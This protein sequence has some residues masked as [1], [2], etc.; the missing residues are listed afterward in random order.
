MTEPQIINIESLRA[1]PLPQW[2]DE[3]SKAD[4]G[5]LLVIAGSRRLAGAALLCA[6]AALRSGCGTVRVAAPQ[7]VALHL[8]IAV[9]ELMVIPLP[10]TASGT[11]ARAALPILEQ[12]FAP[13]DACIVGPGIDADHETDELLRELLP[14]IPLPT[15]IDAQAIYAIGKGESGAQ[16]WPRVWTPHEGELQPIVGK[17]FEELGVSREEFATDFARDKNA[18]LV[19]KGRETLVAVPDGNLWKNTAGTRGMGTAGS[20]DTLSGIIGALLAQ[21]LEPAHAAA[22][23]VHIHALAGEAAAKELGDDGM[24][25]SDFLERIPQ[26]L[27]YLRRATSPDEKPRAGLRRV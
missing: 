25:A 8:G 6:K 13:C 15:V 4:Y 23:S 21:G 24:M 3:S 14:Q 1:S 12:Q 20:G 7:S 18:V 16:N 26:V 2:S 22:W 19:F 10:E 17:K 5:K 11:I 27:R 9:P